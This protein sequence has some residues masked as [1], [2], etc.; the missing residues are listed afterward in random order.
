[1]IIVA[2]HNSIIYYQLQQAIINEVNQE[3]RSS[4][5]LDLDPLQILHII[6]FKMIVD[7]FYWRGARG[8]SFFLSSGHFF[9]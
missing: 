4:L 9:F 7:P 5:S 8:A 3:I 6:S 2:S 1:M